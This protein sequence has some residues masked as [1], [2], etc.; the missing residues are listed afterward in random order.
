VQ[1]KKTNFVC[2]NCCTKHV[3]PSRVLC[4]HREHLVAPCS[5]STRDPHHVAER[6]I[7]GH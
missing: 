2:I 5:S 1:S 7:V 3:L 6:N 4:S